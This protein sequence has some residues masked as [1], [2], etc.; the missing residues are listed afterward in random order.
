MGNYARIKLIGVK[1]TRMQIKKYFIQG[2]K[3]TAVSIYY[4]SKKTQRNKKKGLTTL[5]W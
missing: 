5:K 1:Q 2:K 3:L 4:A